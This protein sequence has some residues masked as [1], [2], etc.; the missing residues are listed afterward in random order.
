[1]QEHA[2]LRSTRA[3]Y[4]WQLMNEQEVSAYRAQ[5]RAMQTQEERN[6]FREQHREAM[7]E[8]ARQEDVTLPE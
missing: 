1:L 3:I 5:L 7:Q 4:G 2:D 8:R 6:R